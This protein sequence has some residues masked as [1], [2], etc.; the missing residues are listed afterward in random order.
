MNTI[1]SFDVNQK[2]NALPI[3]LLE[4]IDKFIDFLNFKDAAKS[5]LFSENQ[6]DLIN[7]G[8]IDIEKGRLIPNK[9]AKKRIKNYIKSKSL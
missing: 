1:T 8:Q 3:A 2:I 5:E 9:E 6:I 4:D 7:K